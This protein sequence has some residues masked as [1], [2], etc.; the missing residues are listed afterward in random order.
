L[1]IGGVLYLC[2]NIEDETMKITDVYDVYLE[3]DHF[4]PTCNATIPGAWVAIVNGHKQPFARPHEHKTED[5]A[6]EAA[7]KLFSD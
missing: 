5:D 6:R 1:A 3:D 7:I 4:N 2:T